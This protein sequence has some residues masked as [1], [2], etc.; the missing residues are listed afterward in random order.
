MQPTLDVRR[1]SD[2]SI[3]FDF[4]RRSA[5]HAQRSARQQAF[6]RGLR[7]LVGCCRA[8]AAGCKNA[9]LGPCNRYATAVAARR[10]HAAAAAFGS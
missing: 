4:Y 2:G 7:F 8:V 3:D 10:D 9:K 6:H 5:F 1:H